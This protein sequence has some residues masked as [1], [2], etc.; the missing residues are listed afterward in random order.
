[1]FPKLFR[2][3]AENVEFCECGEIFEFSC[4]VMVALDECFQNIEEEK[5]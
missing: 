1:M 3:V 5:Y 2:R 4:W